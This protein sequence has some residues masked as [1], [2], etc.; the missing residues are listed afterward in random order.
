MSDPMDASHRIECYLR[1]Q[2]RPDELARFETELLDSPVLQQESLR[3]ALLDES[4]TPVLA[5]AAV[6]GAA[7]RVTVSLNAEQVPAG[8]LWLETHGAGARPLERRL[9]EFRSG[10]DRATEP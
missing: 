5:W 6:P 1:D 10:Q 4:G 2:M 9:L 3:F 7:G 8:R